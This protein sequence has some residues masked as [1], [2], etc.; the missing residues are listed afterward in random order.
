V[1]AASRG[2]GEIFDGREFLSERENSRKNGRAFFS[3]KKKKLKKIKASFAATFAPAAAR[4]A[5]FAVR[6]PRAHAPRLRAPVCAC[7]RLG[8]MCA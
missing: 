2:G 6:A 4:C 3:R 8:N 5:L 1:V 7:V